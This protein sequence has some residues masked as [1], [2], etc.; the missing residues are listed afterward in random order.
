V[1]AD[2]AV[3]FGAA[4]VPAAA[5][6]RVIVPAA[7]EAER[8]SLRPMLLRTGLL[9]LASWA[10]V[11]LVPAFSWM[12]GDIRFYSH[13]GHD[14]WR[15]LMPYRD[16]R[17][18][19][20][21]G[22]LF[23]FVLPEFARQLSPVRLSYAFWFRVEVLALW[24]PMLYVTAWTLRR[25]GAS[26][27][28]MWLSLVVTAAFPLLLG[29]VAASRYDVWP[30]LLTALTVAALVAERPR[31]ACALI[32]TGIVAKLYPV[33]LL[34][35]AL[36]VLWRRDRVRGVLEGAGV[37][38]G[39]CLAGFGLFLARAPE[40]LWHGIWRQLSRPL[41]IESSAASL[42]AFA[43]V[44]GGLHVHPV[45]SY[46]SDNIV[47]HGSGLAASVS[48]LLVGV[49]LIAVWTRF[50][51]GRAGADEI[52]VAVAAAV[53][54]YL[55]FNKVFS[56]QYLIWLL[57]LVVLVRGRLG[58][59]AIGLFVVATVLTQFWEPFLY[60]PLLGYHTLE[61]LLLVVRD[62]LIVGLFV[63]LLRADRTGTVPA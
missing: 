63:L 1:N 37:A 13:W 4:S 39:V 56:P 24:A 54:G 2:Q 12:T 20:P 31:L 29:N 44:V 62:A 30:A 55:A 33:V 22:A 25:L 57:P 28:H 36:V 23:S 60:P 5:P 42:W 53:T 11:S 48:G 40:G 46:G 50:A 61:C 3:T 52:V 14:V 17:L 35:I 47:T 26:R 7:E 10:V 41:Q 6:A 18:E 16:F 32:G 34:P 49:A 58:Q 45:K 19:Y 43:H 21:P 8:D 38:L 9:L 51:R 15:G 27:P 59:F